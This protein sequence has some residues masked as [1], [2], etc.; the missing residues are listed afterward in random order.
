MTFI[1]AAQ[2]TANVGTHRHDRRT[3]REDRQFADAIFADMDPTAPSSFK[4]VWW[5]GMI[6]SDMTAVF[7][8]DPCCADGRSWTFFDQSGPSG[9]SRYGFVGVTRDSFG[10]PARNCTVK[11]FRTSDDLLIDKTV[12]D[13]YGNFLLN[14]PFYPDTHYIVAHKT[15]APPING[16]SVNTLIGS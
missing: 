5:G 7:G 12:S 6:G 1:G 10:A 9:E 14:T 13:L 2:A 3:Q 16:A 15:D 8:A 4:T 11:L